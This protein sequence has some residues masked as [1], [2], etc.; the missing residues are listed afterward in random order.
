MDGR[1]PISQPPPG[2]LTKPLGN[3]RISTT[4]LPQP[5]AKTQ[6]FQRLPSPTGRLGLLKFV[7]PKMAGWKT[8][9]DR[10]PTNTLWAIFWTCFSTRFVDSNQGYNLYFHGLYVI[11]GWKMSPNPRVINLYIPCY[12]QYPEPL[13]RKLF[14]WTEAK[15]S[16][17][18]HWKSYC[19]NVILH[20][21]ECTLR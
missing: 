19:R 4:N 9:N 10:K 13:S 11:S 20:L 6:K 15:K 12:I 14:R 7:K 16:H 8:S 17:P 21:Q 18:N 5:G 1:N 3:T 2:M